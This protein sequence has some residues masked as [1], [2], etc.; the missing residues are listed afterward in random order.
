VKG[1]TGLYA[2]LDIPLLIHVFIEIEC[3]EHDQEDFASL[4]ILEDISER[5]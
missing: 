1:D 3:E 4:A 2:R 5:M